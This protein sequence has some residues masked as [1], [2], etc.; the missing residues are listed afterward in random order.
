MK[1]FSRCFSL[2]MAMVLLC[3]MLTACGGSKV[4]TVYED[5]TVG[6]QLKL[7]AEGET[8]AILHT[9]MGD[10][11]LRLFPEAAPKAVENFITLASQG[12]Y[13]GLIFHYARDEHGVKGGS[14]DGTD[15]VGQSIYKENA[16]GLFKDEFD[17]K[18]LNL[19]GAVAMANGGEPDTNGT[20]FF[21]NQTTAKGFGTRKS[22]TDENIDLMY[23]KV[24]A[25]YLQERGPAFSSLYDSWEKFKE[26]V[27]EQTYIYDWV[28][29]EVWDL[30]ELHGGDITL[31][32][33]WRKSGGNTVFAQVFFGL[34]V[35]DAIVG[36]ETD[37]DHK[38]VKDVTIQS[39]ELTTF[40]TE[41]YQ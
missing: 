16:N 25:A 32:G 34:D 21:I 5:E 24:Y 28:P 17:S 36:V 39:I 10:M 2:V 37:G 38:P 4:G 14:P 20:Q 33:A 41:N 19:R 18:L 8:I 26:A 13:D 30:Y 3:V 22:R 12:Y 29:D 15:A 35:L 1:R 40:K 11:H 9:S 31:D 7:P 6:F 27:Y 23:Q